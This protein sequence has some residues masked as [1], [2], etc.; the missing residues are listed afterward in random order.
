MDTGPFVADTMAS[1]VGANNRLQR[2][3]LIRSY[4]GTS[5]VSLFPTHQL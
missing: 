2:D 4:A 1:L 3:A 5:G